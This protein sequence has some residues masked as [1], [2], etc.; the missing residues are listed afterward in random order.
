MLYIGQLC[1]D[2]LSEVREQT[3]KDK[4][5]FLDECVVSCL[6]A[7]AALMYFLIKGL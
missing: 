3:K 7:S 6:A 5:E 4:N 1:R 2:R